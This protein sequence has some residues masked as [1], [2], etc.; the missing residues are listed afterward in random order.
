MSRFPL[1]DSFS[2]N[3]PSDDLTLS[4]KKTFIRRTSKMDKKGHELLYALIR[5]HQI[6]NNE[7]NTSFTLPYGGTFIEK[8]IN[9]NLDKL[10]I[11]LKQ[12][13]LK[14]SKAHLDKMKEDKKNN[15]KRI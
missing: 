9:F 7:Q 12:I 8:D 13:L 6:E 3:I 5:M 11:I 1:Y 14:F 4:Q 15:G 2:Q 10:P